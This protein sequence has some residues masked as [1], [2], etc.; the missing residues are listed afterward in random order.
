MKKFGSGIRVKHPVS[1]T[2]PKTFVWGNNV[3]ASFLPPHQGK[4]YRNAICT[5]L[6]I[7]C[8]YIWDSE[9]RNEEVKSVLLTPG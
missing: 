8:A 7:Y 1:A 9:R 3:M 4:K 5:N 2:L 6:L